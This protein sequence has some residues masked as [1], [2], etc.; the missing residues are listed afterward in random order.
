MGNH[1]EVINLK[2]K[3]ISLFKL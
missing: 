2:I 3:M 1:G